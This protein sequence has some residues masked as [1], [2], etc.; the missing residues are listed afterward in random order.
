MKVTGVGAGLKGML[1]N[2]RTL[3]RSRAVKVKDLENMMTS[4]SFLTDCN[5]FRLP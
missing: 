4:S 2:D 1:I 3:S 5:D